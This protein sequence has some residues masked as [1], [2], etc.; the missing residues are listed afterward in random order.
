MDTA[1]KLRVS[2]VKSSVKENLS[3]YRAAARQKKEQSA[4][5]RPLPKKKTAQHRRWGRLASRNRKNQIYQREVK[6]YDQ[7]F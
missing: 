2:R 4:A 5:S 6:R 7:R 3:R 1:D